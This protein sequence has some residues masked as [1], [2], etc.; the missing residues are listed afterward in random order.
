MPIP[1]GLLKSHV[2]VD[3]DDDDAL[4]SLYLSAA[5]SYF[6]RASRRLL[7]QQT[8]T[9]KLGS[10]TDSML[11]FPPLVSVTSVQY[12]DGDGATQTLA[13]SEYIVDTT[14][15]VPVLRFTGTMPDL[16]PDVA[17]RVTITYVCGWNDPPADVVRAV[18]ELAAG[19]YLT[20][21]S[22]ALVQFRPVP[23]G[24]ESVIANRSVPEFMPGVDP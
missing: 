14:R 13:G 18:L 15:P 6:E 12:V 4:L 1:L 21:E 19:Y 20:R 5:T 11:P 22:V 17:D 24:V 3:F 10:F 16:D 2:R 23:F 8:R 9:L 7:S